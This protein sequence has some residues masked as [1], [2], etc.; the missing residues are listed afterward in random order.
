[1]CVTPCP[2]HVCVKTV[3]VDPFADGGCER[4]TLDARWRGVST[5]RVHEPCTAGR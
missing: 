4:E 3:H 1:M 2:R 5:I